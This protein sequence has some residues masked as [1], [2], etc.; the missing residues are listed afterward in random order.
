MSA[1]DGSNNFLATGGRATNLPP[2]P[3]WPDDS[4]CHRSPQMKTSKYNI[5]YVGA[6][7]SSRG[8]ATDTNVA[9]CCSTNVSYIVELLRT[10]HALLILWR[11]RSDL[12]LSTD[13]WHVALFSLTTTSYVCNTLWLGW[14]A[15]GRATTWTLD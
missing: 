1:T 5:K 11:T 2:Y 4:S 13:P 14:I 6:A 7:T 8:H 9:A 12:L 3:G 10:F 15:L